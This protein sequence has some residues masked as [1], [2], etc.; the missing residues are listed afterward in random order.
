MICLTKK[1]AKKFQHHPY[2]NSCLANS[3]FLMFF[4]PEDRQVESH[5][6]LQHVNIFLVKGLYSS[7]CELKGFQRRP[8]P[9]PDSILSLNCDNQKCLSTHANIVWEEHTT[10]MD[11]HSAIWWEASIP[12]SLV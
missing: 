12:H 11:T 9:L 3:Y 1:V 4:Q 8:W 5:L 10:P 2:I 6:Q 7:L